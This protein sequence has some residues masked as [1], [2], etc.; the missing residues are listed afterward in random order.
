MDTYLLVA[1]QNRQALHIKII[2]VIFNLHHTRAGIHVSARAVHQVTSNE[3]QHTYIVHCVYLILAASHH[4]SCMLLRT[5]ALVRAAETRKMYMA[6]ITVSIITSHTHTDLSRL[7]S[8]H[9]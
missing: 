9:P 6:S 4:V 1:A 3:I 2:V 8:I 5:T 7:E